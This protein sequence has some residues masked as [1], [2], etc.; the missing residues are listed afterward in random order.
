MP[1]KSPERGVNE[2]PSPIFK[3][4]I[5]LPTYLRNGHFQSSLQA[6]LGIAYSIAFY[7][8]GRRLGESG[9]SKEKP[10]CCK[11]DFLPALSTRYANS[12]L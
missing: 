3:T 4:K 11:D 1:R 8:L 12:R 2:S 9:I 10:K 5:R 7:V 6:K